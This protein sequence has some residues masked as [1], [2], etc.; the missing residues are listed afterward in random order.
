MVDVSVAM[1]LGAMVVGLSVVVII[2]RN[3]GE[4][5]P[6]YRTANHDTALMALLILIS[7]SSL[8]LGRIMDLGTEREVV[9]LLATAGAVILMMKIAREGSAANAR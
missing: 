3:E 2:F 6:Q 8:I 7:A 4:V 9:S 1:G 5:L